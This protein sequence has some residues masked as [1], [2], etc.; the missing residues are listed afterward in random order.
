MGSF[1]GETGGMQDPV[2]F[3]ADTPAPHKDK[4]EF[5]KRILNLSGP[6]LVEMFLVSL[7][8]MID[9]IMVGRLGPASITAVGLTNQPIFF[10]VA[11]FQALNVG[12]TAL[13]AR[14]VGAKRNDRA[15]DVA[16]QSFVLT[17]LAGGILGA[18]G[19]VSASWVIPA[20]GAEEEVISLGVGYMRMISLGLIFNAVAMSLSSSLR[21]AGDTK[22]PMKAN[23]IANIVNV[24][25]N[26]ILI[27]GKLGFPRLGVLGAALATNISRIVACVLVLHVFFS[28]RFVLRLS[29]KDSYRPDFEILGRVLRVGLPTAIE[30]FILRGGQLAY[31]RIV[32]SFGTTVFAAHQIGMNIL[33]LSFMPGQAFAIAAT[34]LVGQELGAKRPDLAEASALETRRLGMLVSGIMALIFIFFGRWVAMLYTNDETVIGLTSMVL[35]VIGVVQP[36]QSTQFIL[37]GGLRGAGDTKWPLYSTFMGIWGVRVLTGYFFAI[38]LH[39]GLLGAWLGMALDQCTRSIIIYTRFKRGAWKKVIV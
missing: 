28:G 23:L 37:A 13:V 16:R 26:Y 22:T 39:M 4:K 32:A 34:T 11:V 10:I 24:V 2:S 18:V 27:Y 17:L 36:A 14:F 33:S 9:M 3:A 20:M 5:R 1:E 31:V 29:L 7:V 21:G 35:K 12:T 25:G 6:A 8:G 38:V 15:A 19:Y 30:Q